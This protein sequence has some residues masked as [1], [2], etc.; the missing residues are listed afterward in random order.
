MN[1]WKT[2]GLEFLNLGGKAGKAKHQHKDKGTD[3]LGLAFGGTAEWGIEA[4][5][6]LHDRSKF[7]RQSFSQTEP[8]SSRSLVRWEESR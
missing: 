8:N 3:D 6:I 1:K 2:V 7:S 4:G 5:K